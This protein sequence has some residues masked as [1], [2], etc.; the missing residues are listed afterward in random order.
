[1]VVFVFECIVIL[2]IQVYCFL[3][4]QVYYFLH[5]NKSRKAYICKLRCVGY[6]DVI[7]AYIGLFKAAARSSALSKTLKI[8]PFLTIKCVGN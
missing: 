4:I 5:I 1:M 7:I 3:H 6:I 8:R 2:H